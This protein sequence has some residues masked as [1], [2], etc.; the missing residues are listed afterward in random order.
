MS[1][2]GEFARQ[3]KQN[4]MRVLELERENAELR[5]ANRTLEVIVMGIRFNSRA[6]SR[7]AVCRADRIRMRKSDR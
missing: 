7:Q 1:T 4:R 2:V 5:Q 3:V 6:K